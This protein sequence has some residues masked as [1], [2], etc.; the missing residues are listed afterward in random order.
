MV[1]KKGKENQLKK[2]FALRNLCLKDI[3]SSL[4]FVRKCIDENEDTGLFSEVID[5]INVKI[6]E[7]EKTTKDIVVNSESSCVHEEHTEYYNKTRDD[8]R[9]LVMQ[10]NKFCRT[11]KESSKT[12][13]PEE[14]VNA[15]VDTDRMFLIDVQEAAT[16]TAA[17]TTTTACSTS[18]SFKKSLPSVKPTE[19]DGYPL[20]WLDWIGLFTAT[21]HSSDMKNAEK[22]THLQTLVT[23]PAKNLISGYGHNGDF[24]ETAIEKLRSNFGK[25]TKVV[26]EFLLHLQ[27]LQ[28]PT[29][30]QPTS[31]KDFSNFLSTMVDT[32]K[33]L[34]FHHDLQSTANVEQVLKKLPITARLEWNRHALAAKVERPTLSRIAEWIEEDA[35]AC[36]DLPNI[37]TKLSDTNYAHNSSDRQK[38]KNSQQQVD[39]KIKKDFCPQNQ[40]CRLL[41]QCE[42]FRHLSLSQRLEHV[43]N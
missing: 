7:L 1:N 33:K 42:H 2:N 9:Q 30:E 28:H 27:R 35:N 24:Y 31:F 40:Q 3:Y 14:N 22:M 34:C 21:V 32:F 29:F 11:Q 8:V 18:K 12:K 5:E 23:G 25:P 20:E 10:F 39:V 19:Y 15:T 37:T 43:K 17:A 36:E 6:K 26:S 16:S 13:T 4:D 41:R 38:A